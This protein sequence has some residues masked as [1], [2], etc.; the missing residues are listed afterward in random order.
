VSE[1]QTWPALPGPR[2]LCQHDLECTLNFA[3]VLAD[4]AQYGF[5][6]DMEYHGW[7]VTGESMDACVAV[8]IDLLTHSQLPMYTALRAIA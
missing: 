8:A 2:S 4:V 3:Q 1:C 7:A 6:N 5:V